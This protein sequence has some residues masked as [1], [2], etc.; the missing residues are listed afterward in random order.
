MNAPGPSLERHGRPCRRPPLLACKVKPGLPR[1]S[2]PSMVCSA[3]ATDIILRPAIMR[4]M[5][6]K[7]TLQFERT[8]AKKGT[9]ADDDPWAARGIFAD[10]EFDDCFR[11]D[12]RF[13][14]C[15]GACLISCFSWCLI[16]TKPFLLVSQ[17]A[18]RIKTA[19]NQTK[20]EYRFN[21]SNATSKQRCE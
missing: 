13:L 7:W 6:L 14:F 20:P 1:A 2:P 18:F 3:S 16:C 9:G 15:F 8:P 5:C 10:V 12:L 17:R 4:L 21:K 19:H 11:G